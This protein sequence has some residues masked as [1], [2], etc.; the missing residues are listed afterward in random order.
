MYGTSST[1]QCRYV[2]DRFFT[3]SE[4]R[5]VEGE[6][7]TNR[8]GRSR[9]IRTARENLSKEETPEKKKRERVFTLSRQ[10]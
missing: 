8:S 4:A 9:A 6:K 7:N 1:I 2:A 3:E 10:V 5:S